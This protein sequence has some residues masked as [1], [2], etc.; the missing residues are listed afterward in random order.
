MVILQKDEKKKR[1]LYQSV[2]KSHLFQ[3]LIIL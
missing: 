2:K 3:I 1:L